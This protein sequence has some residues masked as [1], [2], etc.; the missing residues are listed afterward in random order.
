MLF[1]NK[2][3]LIVYSQGLG[4]ISILTLDNGY[5][6]GL[7]NISITGMSAGSHYASNAKLQ[8]KVSQVEKR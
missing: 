3:G 8:H 1:P 6:S 5:A 7:K 4:H 2:L